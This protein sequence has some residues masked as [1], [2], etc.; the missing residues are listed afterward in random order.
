[1]VNS[2]LIRLALILALAVSSGCQSLLRGEQTGD[3][4]AVVDGDTL[5]LL[6][7]QRRIHKVRLAGID[8]PNEPQPHSAAAKQALFELVFDKS[9]RVQVTQNQEGVLWARV[10]RKKQDINAELVR[11]GWAWA[12]PDGEDSDLSQLEAE[13]RAAARGLWASPRPIPPWKYP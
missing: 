4:I 1:M 12:L 3:V 8:A 2:I 13:A 10:F 9:V 7:A 5:T 11:R 6:D